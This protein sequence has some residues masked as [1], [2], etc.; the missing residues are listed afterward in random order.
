MA[1]FHQ[2]ARRQP[3][4]R[5]PAIVLLLIAALLAIHATRVVFYPEAMPQI[6]YQYGFIPAR[7]SH[8]YLSSHFVRGGSLLERAIPFASYM[9]LHADWTHVGMNSIWLLPFGS[10]VARRYGGGL[11]LLFFLICGIAGAAIHLALNWGSTSP[12]IGA[13]A[14]I[15]GMMGV[16][17]RVTPNAPE[18]P[19]HPLFS[20]PVV[21]FSLVWILINAVAGMTGFGAGPG[22]HL[23][24]WEAHIGGYFAGL[25][26]AGPFDRVSHARR[27]YPEEA[28]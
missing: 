7:Y 19:L 27:K 18:A 24:A 1:F 6:V 21:M 3:F 25:L 10:M 15:S 26:L 17:F 8:Q 4:L 22:V 2:P 28:A 20:R 9:F 13:S 11:F 5:A 12:V 23:V 14:A 16:A